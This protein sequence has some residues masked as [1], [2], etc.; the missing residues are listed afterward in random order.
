V[1]WCVWPEAAELE[2]RAVGS[3]MGARPVVSIRHGTE[4]TGCLLR[5]IKRLGDRLTRAAGFPPKPDDPAAG[6]R[7]ARKT[8][9]PNLSEFVLRGFECRYPQCARSRL[10]VIGQPQ[11]AQ[12]VSSELQ[13]RQSA[14]PLM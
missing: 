12:E 8:I 14:A 10:L 13:T 3:P 5:V 9:S 7:D 2:G 11:L 6:G 1:L 4:A